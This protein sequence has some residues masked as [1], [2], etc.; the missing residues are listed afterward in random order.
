[1]GRPPNPEKRGRQQ[2]NIHLDPVLVF[3]VK[4]KLREIRGNDNL[5]DFVTELLEAFFMGETKGE[6]PVKEEIKKIVDEKRREILSQHKL[7]QEVTA[8]KDAAEQYRLTRDNAVRSATITVLSTVHNFSR[9]LPEHDI[10]GDYVDELDRIL[11]KISRK[12]GY[13]VELSD[14]L[15][16]WKELSAQVSP[17]EHGAAPS[18]QLERAP[19]HPLVEE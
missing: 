8:S 18:C 15:S 10:Y 4:R 3:C 9:Y 12:A 17:E 6:D 19:G 16:I 11:D 2:T 5:S 1:M 13:E 14:V 7:F